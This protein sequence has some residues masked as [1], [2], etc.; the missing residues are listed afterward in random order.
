[1]HAKKLVA[2]LFFIALGYVIFTKVYQPPIMLTSKSEH[3]LVNATYGSWT[4]PLTAASIFEGADN[5][6]TLTVAN[7]QLYF[8]ERRAAANGRNILFRLDENKK[9]EQLTRSE[10]SVRSAVHEYGGRPYLVDGQDIYYSR[11]SDQKIYK[12]SPDSEPQALTIDGMR[13]MECVMDSGHQQLI[14]VQE[15]HAGLGEVV[16]TLVAITLTD[17]PEVHNLFSG[18]DFVA[19]PQLSPDGNS[20]AFITWS[21]PNM[22]W[23][24]TQ[25]RIVSLD[26]KG[27][28]IG[29]R[30][31]P[32]NGNVSIDSPL[33]AADGSLYF[34]ADFDNWWTLYRLAA[35]GS[36]ERVL[37]ADIEISSYG[38]ENPKNAI[39]SYYK[40]GMAYLGRV[41]LLEGTLNNIGDAFATADSIATTD[42][43]VY[44]IA[45]TPTTS[46]AIYRLSGDSY[47]EVYRPNGPNIALGYLSTPQ[48]ITFPTGNNEQAF[49]FYYPPNNQDYAGPADSLPP[50]IVKVHGGPVAAA[51]ATLNPSIQFWTSR[52]FAVFDVNHRGSTGYGR[53]FRKKL[54]PNWG[55]VDIEDAANGVQWL[56][57]QHLVDGDKVAI[58]GGSAGGYTTLAALA[59]QNV[60]KAGTSYYGISDLEILATDTHKFESRYLDQLIGPYPEMKHIYQQRSPLNSVDNIKVPLLL[61]QGLD[62]KVVPPN[63]SQLIFDALK[64]NCI[65]TA[66]ITFEGEGHGF[67]Q[68]KNN[69]KSLNSELDFYG[70]IFGF[71][72]AGDIEPIKLETCQN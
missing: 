54:Y 10:V 48:S 9:A 52:G 30:E 67:R 24:D 70:Q 11:F 46:S 71:T 21:H 20:V 7:Q 42:D 60:F 63:Q 18:T 72:P 5:I 39:I 6:S 37:D 31:V 56:V 23:D 57:S 28:P 50:L 58:R 32:Q 43:G 27:Q 69:I 68:P 19:Q 3:P 26:E 13:Y 16:N 53:E 2:V 12:Q 44:F 59:F 4:S 66:Y 35:D 65:P 49:G 62:D 29:S 47:A 25:L 22:P 33:Y 15:D 45:S 40:N 55:I 8:I 17:E 1:M 41:N 38:F 64:K 14:C 61:L 34:I 51:H 36:P